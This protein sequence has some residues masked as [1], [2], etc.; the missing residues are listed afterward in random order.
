MSL[1]ELIKYP[2][3]RDAIRTNLP[4]E[5]FK[6]KAKIKANPQTRNFML[7]GTAFDYLLRFYMERNN[8]KNCNV[9]TKKWVARTALDF[10]RSRERHGRAIPIRVGKNGSEDICSLSE[11]ISKIKKLVHKAEK[12]HQTYINDGKI[13]DSLL[14]SCIHLAQIDPYYRAYYAITKDMGSVNKADVADLKEIISHVSKKKFT[15]KRHVLLNPTFGYGS[16]LVG[17]ADADIIIDNTLIDIKTTIDPTFKREY[18]DQLVGY[19]ILSLL[20]RTPPPSLHLN[21][22]VAISKIGIYFSRYGVL[23]TFRTKDILHNPKFP[24][25]VE[26]FEKVATE[27]Y[28]R[29][30]RSHLPWE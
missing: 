23:R 3:I 12:N 19:Y 7:I 27:Q 8:R 17:G 9:I 29:G 10:I 25:L 24:K 16:N 13:T 1:I 2:V 21:K 30:G 6:I 18:H 5:P 11:I 28:L 22:G 26:T 15:A 20:G 4:F 14:K